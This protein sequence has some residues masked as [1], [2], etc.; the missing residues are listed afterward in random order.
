MREG[1]ELV[2]AAELHQLT[3]VGLTADAVEGKNKLREQ[4]ANGRIA[5][6]FVSCD[7]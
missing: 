6:G 1:G 2:G 5:N 4:S 7:F 3:E